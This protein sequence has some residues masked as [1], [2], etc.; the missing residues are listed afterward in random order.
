MNVFCSSYSMFGLLLQLIEPEIIENSLFYCM[1]LNPSQF[2]L[3]CTPGAGK[4]IGGMENF[5]FY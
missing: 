3:S 2:L 4:S 1:F 5:A